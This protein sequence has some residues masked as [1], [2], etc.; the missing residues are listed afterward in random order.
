MVYWMGIYIDWAMT[1]P[2]AIFDTRRRI[3]HFLHGFVHFLRFLVA[4]S[5]G[6]GS[7]VG[8]PFFVSS[9]TFFTTEVFEF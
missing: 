5:E 2:L 1:P 4:C 6:F 8:G 7:S 3:F 9:V